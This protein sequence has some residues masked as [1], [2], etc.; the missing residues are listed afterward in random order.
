[1]WNFLFLLFNLFCV[2]VHKF[3]CNNINDLTSGITV[4]TLDAFYDIYTMLHLKVWN[5]LFKK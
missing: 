2:T 5:F 4:Q 3:H 1:M